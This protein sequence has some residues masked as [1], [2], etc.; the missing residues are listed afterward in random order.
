MSLRALSL[1]EHTETETMLVENVY[2]YHSY[3]E[4]KRVFRDNDFLDT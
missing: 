3:K 4:E 1:A 2:C